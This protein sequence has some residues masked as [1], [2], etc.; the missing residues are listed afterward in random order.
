MLNGMDGSIVE[1]R[2][3]VGLLHA[4][5]EGGNGL[6]AHLVLPAYID[7]AQQLVV[8]D[9]KRRDLVHFFHRIGFITVRGNAW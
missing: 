2:L 6:A 7:T 5:V 8:I 4:D 3:A 1:Y 9:R